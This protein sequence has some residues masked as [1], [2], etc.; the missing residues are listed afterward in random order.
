MARYTLGRLLIAVPTV[1]LLSV[2][3]FGIMRVLPGDVALI[4]LAG[5]GEAS[6]SVSERDLSTL[7]EKLGL[8][9]SAPEQYLTWIGNILRLD[10]GRSTWNG[11]PIGPD[12][13]RGLQ[14]TLELAVLA[15]LV[16]VVVS[17]PLG[18][19]AAVHQ[20]TW[21][22]YGVRVLSMTGIA[23]PSFWT[24]TLIL[25]VLST[26]VGWL[27]SLVYV[28]PWAN[29]Q[30]NLLQMAWPAAVLGYA[31]AAVITRMTRSQMLEILRQDYVRT[32]WAKG[33]GGRIVLYRHAL[34]N[35]LL[36]VVTLLGLEFAILVG[37]AVVI[38]KVFSLPG[39]G[40]YLVEATSARDYPVVQTVILV[41]GLLVALVNLGVDLLYGVLD[42]RVRY[43]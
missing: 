3:I 21:V 14:V 39:L 13:A 20:D 25:L 6:N 7:R 15:L 22:D 19:L 27:P 34:K 43:G 17:I 11:Q 2:L 12:I 10:L 33:L 18:V 30:N 1:L 37:G 5:S 26:A 28:P 16:S 41:I 36:P 35:A 40:L 24:G 32:A 31:Q 4:M 29:L 38:E 42:P 9:R 23:M 8:T